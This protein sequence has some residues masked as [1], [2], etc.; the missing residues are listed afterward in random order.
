[1]SI[2]LSTPLSPSK[3]SPRV[4]SP[5]PTAAEAQGDL[6]LSRKRFRHLSAINAQSEI[7]DLL[8]QWEDSTSPT[9]FQ[10]CGAITAAIKNGH[11]QLLKYLVDRGLSPLEWQAGVAACSYADS[12]GNL[13]ILELLVEHGW[14]PK[15]TSDGKSRLT[16]V[17]KH[18]ETLSN[19]QLIIPVIVV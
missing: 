3:G 17:T 14:D 11:K 18:I 19:S 16:L 1:M 6:F 10:L 5:T 7:E 13:E 12:T 9:N 2:P 8:Q 4:P 15:V